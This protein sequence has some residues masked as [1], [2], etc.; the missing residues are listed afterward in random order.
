MGYKLKNILIRKIL[1]LLLWIFQV[2][3]LGAHAEVYRWVDE[4]GTMHFS[5]KPNRH[6]SAEKIEIKTGAVNKDASQ[7][8]RLKDQ[9]H[10]LS[11][12]EEERKIKQQKQIEKQKKKEEK[13]KSCKKAR[14]TLNEYLTSGQ[15]YDLDK[16]G[17]KIYLSDDEREQEI[18]KATDAVDY[19]CK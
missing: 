17:N 16:E 4:Q 7:E 2:T 18:K 12:L 11:V 6:T 13:K 19:W 10:L 9:K 5:D 14:E 3:P 8:R 1:V 15:L